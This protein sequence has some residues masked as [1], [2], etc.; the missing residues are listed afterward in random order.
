MLLG[1]VALGRTW[2][3]L[4]LVLAYG[5]GMAVSLVGAGLLLLRVIARLGHRAALRD[6]FRLTAALRAP[7]DRDLGADRR[8]RWVLDA[9]IRD[10]FIS[11]DRAWLG[12]P[13]STGLRTDGSCA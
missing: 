7:A 8:R 9:D 4:T 11:L 3:G 10:F 5:V 2:F 12:K 6:R 1:G 13:S